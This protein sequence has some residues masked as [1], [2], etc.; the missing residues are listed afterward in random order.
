MS[1]GVL[2]PIFSLK[3]L[4]F[5][6]KQNLNFVDKMSKIGLNRLKKRLK[7]ENA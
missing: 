3:V 6:K 2:K 7:A 4:L 5:S 1:F